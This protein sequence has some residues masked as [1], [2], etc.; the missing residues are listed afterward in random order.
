MPR[1]KSQRI[2]HQPNQIWPT[3]LLRRG[4]TP[5]K[6]SDSGQKPNG[7]PIIRSPK[8]PK[9]PI[10]GPVYTSNLFSFFRYGIEQIMPTSIPSR[11]PI[12][13]ISTTVITPPRKRLLDAGTL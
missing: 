9:H 2:L 3:D 8:T 12:H 4:P 7:T 13:K 6:S 5:Y 10:P 1:Q 11:F